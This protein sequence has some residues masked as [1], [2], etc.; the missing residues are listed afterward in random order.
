MT[1]LLQAM[2][3]GPQ[4]GAE[5]HFVRLAVAL[6]RAGVEQRIVTRPNPARDAMLRAGG[7]EPVHA[8]FGGPFDLKTRP[9][10]ARA[11]REFRPEIVLSYMSRATAAIPAGDFVHVARLGGYYDLKYYR[12][13]DHLVTITEGLAEHVVA[14]GW[15]RS[16]VTV[17]ANFVEDRAGAA[18]AR[19]ARYETPDDAP[20]VFALGR[21]HRNKAFDVLL[22]ATARIEGA[23]LWLAGEGPERAALET[24]A[25]RLGIASRVRFLGWIDDPAPL[26]AAADI[27]A[28]PSRHEPLGSVL[29]EGWM[30]R[31]PMVA[32]ASEGPREIL[33]DGETALMVRVDDAEALAQAIGRLMGDRALAARLAAAG[34]KAYEAGYTEAAAVKSYLELFDRLLAERRKGAA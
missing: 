6:A 30:H 26:F 16:R 8:R 2:A 23:W 11:I 7:I 21:L 27:F 15:P 5:L 10:L 14:H 33:R 25:A 13:C 22:E 3:G 34:R 4:G 29:I 12:R 31:V 20:L 19:R 9:L 32:A 17:I 24:Q 1:R 28:V 18:P